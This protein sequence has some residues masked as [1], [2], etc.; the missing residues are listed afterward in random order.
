MLLH[1]PEWPKNL[2]TAAIVNVATLG[3]IGQRLRAPGTWGSLAGLLYFTTAFA[4]LGVVGSL[5]LSALGVYLAIGFCGEAETR[6]GQ[7]DPGAVVLDEF[8][9][10]PLCFLGWHWLPGAWP[11]WAIFFAGFGLFRF[12][13]VVKPLGIRGLQRL[14]GGWGVVIDDVAAA[15]ATCATLHIAA[16]LW[17]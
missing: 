1:Q 16:A 11:N 5:V 12:F 4:G 6:L 2:P 15:L 10:M 17:P 13:D 14:P 3:P 8:V 7:T 9:A